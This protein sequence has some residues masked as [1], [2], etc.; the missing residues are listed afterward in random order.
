MQRHILG[1]FTFFSNTLKNNTFPLFFLSLFFITHFVEAASSSKNEIMLY[2]ETEFIKFKKCSDSP[3]VNYR[4]S[5]TGTYGSKLG[6]NITSYRSAI[7]QPIVNEFASESIIWPND[8]IDTLDSITF[9][10]NKDYID[11]KG[12]NVQPFFKLPDDT[13]ILEHKSLDKYKLHDHNFRNKIVE[14]INK[15]KESIIVISPTDGRRPLHSKFSDNTKN[16]WSRYSEYYQDFYKYLDENINPEKT[17]LLYY[18]QDNNIPVDSNYIF[19]DRAVGVLALFNAFPISTIHEGFD[20]SIPLKHAI[21]KINSIHPRIGFF[22]YIWKLNWLELWWVRDKYIHD[23]YSFIEE[24]NIKPYIYIS[25]NNIQSAS[26]RD[27]KNYYVISVMNYCG[28]SFYKAA[29][30]SFFNFFKNDSIK[31][32]NFF[33]R[34]DD[35]FLG[36]K[37]FKKRLIPGKAN[38]NFTDKNFIVKELVEIIQ[39]LSDNFL[40]ESLYLELNKITNASKGMFECNLI[41]SSEV[42]MVYCK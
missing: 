11:V 27:L 6:N 12:Y 9:D 41:E 34:L 30:E 21:Q 10:F 7:E 35:I 28:P 20:H 16:R 22:D 37:L 18:Y 3:Y 26:I 29:N 4:S 8:I 32:R 15:R 23:V 33:D 24:N 19:S 31:V 2:M 17:L 5:L 1:T 39:G 40:K 25:Q 14:A 42:K 36:S 13:Y 38:K